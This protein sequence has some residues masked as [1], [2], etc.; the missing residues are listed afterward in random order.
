VVWELDLAQSGSQRI[1][2]SF[3]NGAVGTALGQAKWI[4]A[5]DRSRQVIALPGDGFNILI[6]EFLTAVHHKL[7]VKVVIYN[8]DEFGLIRLGAGRSGCRP[9][10]RH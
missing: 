8:T 2:G 9:T 3:N 6:Y 4:Q 10:G 5:L 7:P 1:I